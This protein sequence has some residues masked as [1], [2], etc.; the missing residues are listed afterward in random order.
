MRPTA[1]AVIC[2]ITSFA[3]SYAAHQA[4]HSPRVTREVIS[5]PGAQRTR[6]AAIN[7]RGQVVGS[8]TTDPQAGSSAFI[9]TR[10]GGFHI[11]ATNVSP[12]DI[13][14]RGQV[15]GGRSE[16]TP[17]PDGGSQC[18]ARGFVWDARTGF[19]DVGDFCSCR[20][21]RQGRHGRILCQWGTGVCC[22]CPPRWVS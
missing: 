10:A 3:S 15:V 14:N 6:P 22:L 4:V 17:T 7:N 8:F 11:F 19:R 2:F 5:F 9:W 20:N 16:C 18:V 13:N 21:Q 1:F 12:E